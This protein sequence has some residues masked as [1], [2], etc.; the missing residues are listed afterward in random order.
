MMG[1]ILA[2]VVFLLRDPRSMGAVLVILATVW[3]VGLLDDLKGTSPY[4][5]LAVDFGCGAALWLLGWR[6]QWFSNPVLDFAATVAFLA[7]AINSMN[8]LDGMDGLAL[9]VGGIASIGFILLLSEQPIGFAS[10]LA[11]SLAAVSAA[12]F[13]FNRPPAQMFIG[14]SGSTLLGASLAFLA[15][16]WVR[17]DAPTHSSAV[18]LLFLG[19]PLA[20][21]F[22]AVIRRLRGRK[23][24]FAG[25][26][27]H[28]YDLLLRRGWSVPKI[29]RVSGFTTVALVMLALTAAH[30]Q[31][32]WWLPL[33]GCVGLYGFLGMQLGS[34]DSGT[35]ESKTPGV[36]KTI[37]ST[38]L[39]ASPRLER[40]LGED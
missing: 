20:D 21:A 2:S 36:R 12:M 37:S 35:E 4:L 13:L 14:D 18:P 10:G 16:D 7:F 39:E 3:A 28:F 29:L 1:G 40:S 6:L 9:T 24:P 32:A 22:A 25:D 23:S 11:W 15:L 31:L 38:Q 26:R 27:R 33:C 19:I 8:M 30:D 5:R 17:I 34:F